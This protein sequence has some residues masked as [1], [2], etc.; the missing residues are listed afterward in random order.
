MAEL[1]IKPSCSG[2]T[3]PLVSHINSQPQGNSVS[4][5]RNAGLTET[6]VGF[7]LL[8]L[9]T[10]FDHTT[11]LWFINTQNQVPPFNSVTLNRTVWLTFQNISQEN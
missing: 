5:H 8:T 6:Q 11:I 7:L 1:G 10:G 4:I 3:G 2:P 9:E